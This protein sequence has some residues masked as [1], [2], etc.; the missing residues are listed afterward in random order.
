MVEEVTIED[1]IETRI[2]TLSAGVK[3]KVWKVDDR[4][5]LF[6]CVFIPGL[7]VTVKVT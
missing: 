1:S 5:Q 6:K 4:K 3:S 7:D 2:R